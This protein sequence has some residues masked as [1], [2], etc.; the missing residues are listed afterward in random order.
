MGPFC[1]ALNQPKPQ[2]STLTRTS[3]IHKSSTSHRICSVCTASSSTPRSQQV[4]ESQQRTRGEGSLWTSIPPAAACS[5]PLLSMGVQGDTRPSCSSMT[6]HRPRTECHTRQH[7]PQM[8]TQDPPTFVFSVF[9][10]K[11]EGDRGQ[12]ATLLSR[13][14]LRTNLC[15]SKQDWKDAMNPVSSF[16]GSRGF[17]PFTPKVMP[18]LEKAGSHRGGGGEETA[19]S[20]F[21]WGKNQWGQW[22]IPWSWASY[23][24]P[25]TIMWSSAL[26]H[27]TLGLEVQPFLTRQNAFSEHVC[28]WR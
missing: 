18:P 9:F 24:P 25:D 6:A 8:L 28:G 19:L 16:L 23:G 4:Q 15:R 2:S 14:L 20:S 5:W 1:Q 7:G 13:S 22:V 27:P 3:S 10:R 11:E 17:F 26:E 12:G 21:V